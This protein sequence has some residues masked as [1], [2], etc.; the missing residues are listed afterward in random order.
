MKG[1]GMGVN[2]NENDMKIQRMGKSWFN[3]LQGMGF[4]FHTL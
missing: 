1:T 3:H 4:P 2:A